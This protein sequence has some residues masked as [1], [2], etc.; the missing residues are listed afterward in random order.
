MKCKALASVRPSGFTYSILT[1]LVSSPCHAKQIHGH[2][3]I[4]GCRL[5]CRLSVFGGWRDFGSSGLCGVVRT[6]SEV[7]N[8]GQTNHMWQTEADVANLTHV[9]WQNVMTKLF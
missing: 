3:H 4:H 7:V 5:A 9:T 6:I 8:L 2:D 1:S